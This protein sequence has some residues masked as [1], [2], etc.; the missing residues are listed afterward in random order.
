MRLMRL[1]GVIHVPDTRPDDFSASW[2]AITG[3]VPSGQQTGPTVTPTGFDT[4]T[5]FLCLTP[6]FTV[7]TSGAAAVAAGTAVWVTS[8]TLAPGGTL[9][10]RSNASPGFN[11]VVVNDLALDG[12][13]LVVSWSITT[14]DSGNPKIASRT[15]G[16]VLAPYLSTVP[17]GNDVQLVDVSGTGKLSIGTYPI[18]RD[19]DT[20]L[21]PGAGWNG[22]IE[23][24]YASWTED[25]TGRSAPPVAEAR[26]T[27]SPNCRILTGYHQRF[28]G[29]LTFVVSANA[30]GGVAK[31]RFY[32]EGAYVDVT[33]R[34]NYFYVDSNGRTRVLKNVYCVTLDHSAFLAQHASGNAINLFVRAYPTDTSMQTRML[35]STVAA[36]GTNL[37]DLVRFF[38][39]PTTHDKVVWIDI[40]QPNT[41]TGLPGG[42]DARFSNLDD[43]FRWLGAKPAT[44]VTTLPAQKSGHIIVKTTH[45]WVPLALSDWNSASGFNL[46]TSWHDIECVAGVRL[47]I[48]HTTFAGNGTYCWNSAISGV[49]FRHGVYF[50]VTFDRG[51]VVNLLIGANARSTGRFLGFWFD[52]CEIGAQVDLN[53][54]IPLGGDRSIPEGSLYCGYSGP[55]FITDAVSAHRSCTNAQIVRNTLFKDYWVD[56]FSSILALKGCVVQRLDESF[57]DGNNPAFTVTYAG[58]KENARIERR[59]Y[60]ASS[61]ARTVALESKNNADASWTTDVLL[62]VSANWRSSMAVAYV[63]ANG[64]ASGWSASQ[65][66]VQDSIDDRNLIALSVS[67]WVG[68][69]YDK[70]V[71]A[72][73][74]SD[75]ACYIKSNGAAIIPRINGA[76]KGSVAGQLS[77]W[78]FRDIHADVYQHASGTQNV[79][80]EE[81]V[82]E[83]SFGAQPFNLAT[84]SGSI[85]D[86]WI[87]NNSY[88]T[89]GV[90]LILSKAHTYSHFVFAHNNH[91]AW[92]ELRPP[93]TYDAYCVVANNMVDLFGPNTP[94]SIGALSI[95][96]NHASS[97]GTGSQALSGCTSSGTISGNIVGANADVMIPGMSDGDVEP[98]KTLNDAA[99]LA[100]FASLA[101]DIAGFARPS[102]APAGAKAY[103]ATAATWSYALAQNLQINAVNEPAA[104][105]ANA[106]HLRWK[107]GP[108]NTGSD[109]DL[110]ITVDVEAAFS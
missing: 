38:P 75:Q 2:P 41:D 39:E 96:N 100:P 90:F 80:V 88:D 65:D 54:A 109:V 47:T 76:S 4:P 101:V 82:T 105:G 17:A 46:G 49:R 77:L 7:T 84:S 108:G 5:P 106:F 10:P 99:L 21:G 64:A 89:N 107:D 66:C 36:A 85:E 87:A 26:T 22:A 9:T 98:D 35:G 13:T 104:S 3:A 103:R 83:D 8:G 94:G 81:L 53:S 92:L 23:S 27:A 50:D 86:Y 74:G 18:Y 6:G 44:G 61:G 24:G 57:W 40:T 31:V 33:A 67:S 16:L 45:N 60:N 15:G 28:N 59:G 42:V 34:K 78:V 73:P 48:G 55:L 29:D 30:K 62:D 52:G 102:P 70:T 19:G 1:R 79:L 69:F 68:D 97:L 95:I 56:Q 25:A 20:L 12:G 32:C 71:N 93:T 14:M 58:A 110:T 51:P 11:D 72:P 63:N 91:K 37:Q 43:A